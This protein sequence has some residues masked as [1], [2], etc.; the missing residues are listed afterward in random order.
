MHVCAR[1]FIRDPAQNPVSVHPSA[2][3]QPLSVG[4][5]LEAQERV[6]FS[7]DTCVGMRVCW[8]KAQKAAATCQLRHVN[9]RLSPGERLNRC[10]RPWLGTDSC[11]RLVQAPQLE[12]SK[13]GISCPLSGFAPSLLSASLFSSQKTRP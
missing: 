13:E 2:Q 11:W 6:L 8:D 9:T 12:E 5:F 3:G 7:C 1:V 10:C 4:G